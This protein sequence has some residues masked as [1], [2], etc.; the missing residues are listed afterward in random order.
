MEL[1][2]RVEAKLWNNLCCYW[3]LRWL[4]KAPPL[5]ILFSPF[6]QWQDTIQKGFKATRHQIA[7]EQLQPERFSDFDLVVPLTVPDV[8]TAARNRES[9]AH[10]L[11]PSPTEQAVNLCDDKHAFN[12]A[13]MDK[14]LGRYI[15]PMATML[16]PPYI[17]KR[18]TGGYGMHTYLITREAD[19]AEH[20][21]KIADPAYFKQQMIAGREEYA[22]HVIARGGEIVTSL[23]IRY[24]FH[25]ELPVKG[26]NRVICKHICHCPHLELF[27]DILRAIK[28]EGL[29]CFNYKMQGKVPMILEINPRFGASLCPYFAIF[30][31]RLA[32]MRRS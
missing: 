17:L 18:S 25:E 15:P 5:K 16:K 3:Q 31:S 23:N 2:R 20:Q 8:L 1:I 12:L 4:C 6:E 24:T 22:T 32:M 10:S 14:G 19:E 30:A 27:A 11:L 13:L 7:F 29:C 9:I 28:Y 26:K 21:E